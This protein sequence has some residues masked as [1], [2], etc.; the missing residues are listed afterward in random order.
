MK[1]E[2]ESVIMKENTGRFKLACLLPLLEGD[3]PEEL[4]ISGE[5]KLMKDVLKDHAILEDYLEIKEVM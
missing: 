4:G 5:G 1:E 3:L 2:V